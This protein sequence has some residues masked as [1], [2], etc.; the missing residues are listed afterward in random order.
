MSKGSGDRGSPEKRRASALWC[1]ECG[2][3][4]SACKCDGASDGLSD[5]LRWLVKHPI[6]RQLLEACGYSQAGPSKRE[7]K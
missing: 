5:E 7:D 4:K 6:G 3:G 1:G 2:F